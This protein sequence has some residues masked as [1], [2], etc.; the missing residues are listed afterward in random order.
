MN[1]FE[2]EDQLITDKF[3][4]GKCIAEEVLKL[5]K[6]RVKIITQRQFDKLMDIICVKFEI[7][8]NDELNEFVE[9]KLI[10]ALE[11]IKVKMEKLI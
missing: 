3:E 2:E 8:L 4:I 9:D 10:S 1:E 6:K 11:K 5:K 7:D